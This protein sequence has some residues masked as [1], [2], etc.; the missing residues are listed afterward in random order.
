MGMGVGN[1]GN[2]MSDINVTPLV[3]VMLVLLI[4]IGA[5]TSNSMRL[6]SIDFVPVSSVYPKHFMTTMICSSC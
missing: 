3:D 2:A 4:R 1:N 5:I 6:W